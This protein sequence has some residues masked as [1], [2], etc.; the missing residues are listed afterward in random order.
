M[1]QIAPVAFALRNDSRF[2]P[3]RDVHT[4]L[5]GEELVLVHLEGGAFFRLNR[6][7]RLVWERA[8]GEE[9]LAEMIQQ[10]QA[11]WRV[12]EDVV[13]KDVEAVMVA[14]VEHGLLEPITEEKA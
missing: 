2:R 1:S 3:T 9:T 8:R 12:A 4:E 10:L 5:L 7:G 13:R 14:L 11:S 6:T